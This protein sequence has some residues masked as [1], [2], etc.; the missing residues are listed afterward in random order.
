MKDLMFFI[1]F[2]SIFLI[3]YS[4]TSYSLLTTNRQ[5]IWN[6]TIYNRSSNSYEIYQN[7]VGLWNRSTVRNVIEWGIWK[8]YGQVDILDFSQVDDN[9]LKGRR[10]FMILL[11][12]I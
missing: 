8:I 9:K 2:V 7:G 5:V 11:Y 12:L 6:N 4:I 10:N 1:C 3:S